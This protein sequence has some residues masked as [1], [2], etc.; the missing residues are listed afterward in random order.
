MTSRVFEFDH[1]VGADVNITDCDF[2][3][4]CLHSDL[5]NNCTR[6]HSSVNDRETYRV[7]DLNGQRFVMAVLGIGSVDSALTEE[8]RAVFDSI[9]F[10][11][12]P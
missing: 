7:V 9:E 1:S 10:A 5:G 4:I 3:K 12:G 2:G 11:P 6:W 8:A